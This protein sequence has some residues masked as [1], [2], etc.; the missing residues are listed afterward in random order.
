MKL[1]QLLEAIGDLIPGEKRIAPQIKLRNL[2]QVQNRIYD[3]K[4]AIEKSEDLKAIFQK[5]QDIQNKLNGLIQRV[6]RRIEILKKVEARPT[7]DM[8]RM[9]ATLES[10]CSEFIP[11]MQQADKFLYRGVRNH[12]HAF[13]GRSR[14]DR[15]P[16]DSNKEVSEMFDRMMAELGVQALRNNSIYTT[17]SYGFASSYGWEVYI[18]FPKNGF[19]FLSTNQGDL[20]LEKWPQLVDM[21]QVKGKLLELDAWAK[22][23]IPDKWPQSSLG[24]AI[25]Y[26]E[27]DYALR[28]LQDTW[29]YDN[30]DLGLPAEYNLDMKSLVTP[31]SVKERFEPNTTDL[32]KAIK[33]GNECLIRGEYWALNHKRWEPILRARYLPHTTAPIW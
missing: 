12:E 6:N 31:E 9:F 13:E 17:S 3:L 7:E 24:S 14:E 29:K 28:L 21:E 27:W 23:N 18:I 8:K 33:S 20:I 10:E 19:E 11:T 1:V 25:R 4:A 16:K 32:V 26:R 2:E 15:E 30:N 22:V 5:D